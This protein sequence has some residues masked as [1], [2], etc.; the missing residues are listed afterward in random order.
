[1][2]KLSLSRASLEQTSVK[3]FIFQTGRRAMPSIA[4]LVH[5]AEVK[6]WG[7]IFRQFW[8][9][10]ALS[11]VITCMVKTVPPR[12]WSYNLRTFLWQC[13]FPLPILSPP[14]TT[15]FPIFLHSGFFFF[16]HFFLHSSLISEFCFSH[17]QARLSLQL[18]V[19]TDTWLSRNTHSSRPHCFVSPPFSCQ[20]YI[21]E[22]PSLTSF[23]NWLSAFAS[24]LLSL[25]VFS[26]LIVPCDFPSCHL[27]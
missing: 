4:D 1:M 5:K 20:V 7:G 17:S 2:V 25:V 16:F 10:S 14:L 8:M 22:D 9:F 11:A 18:S 23:P 12:Q 3:S 26:I 13:L 24:L 15:P 21:S 19:S 6:F 27:Q